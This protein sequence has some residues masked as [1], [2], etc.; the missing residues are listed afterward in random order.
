MISE[1]VEDVAEDFP[2]DEKDVQ[3]IEDQALHDKGDVK[4]EDSDSEVQQMEYDFASGTIKVI[5]DA[6]YEDDS[7]STLDVHP[8]DVD[9]DMDIT[10][11]NPKLFE[12]K[13]EFDNESLN[14]DPDDKAPRPDHTGLDTQ[15][16]KIVAVFEGAGANMRTFQALDKDHAQTSSR[17]AS[18]FGQNPEI[19]IS[20]LSAAEAQGCPVSAVGG[21]TE[22]EPIPQTVIDDVE[23]DDLFEDNRP[24]VVVEE[25]EELEEKR[26]KSVADVS[27]S[28]AGSMQVLKEREGEE[29]Y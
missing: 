11:T 18:P 12:P 14:S 7:D 23:V 15:V 9:D 25:V 2:T 1:D 21:L 29:H 28:E 13:D 20:E 17:R 4:S 3:E 6:S 16:K 24:R 5:Q 19:R 26:M 10:P 22:Q 8:E 27:L